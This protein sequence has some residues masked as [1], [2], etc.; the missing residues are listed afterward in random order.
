M[1][2]KIIQNIG[3]FTFNNTTV[4]SDPIALK[5]GYLRIAN[6]PHFSH[7]AIGTDV[8]A[9]ENDF[10]VSANESVIL[11]EKVS[12][13]SIFDIVPGSVTTIVAPEG[14]GQPFEV[15]DYISI[16]GVVN[17]VGINTN[18]VEVLSVSGRIM[19]VNLDTSSETGPFEFNN[20]QSR[21]SVKIS[22]SSTHGSAYAHVSE[23][24]IA[25]G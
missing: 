21:R 5:S 2:L 15:G 13:Q 8:V 25:G 17:P 23:V 10:G 22:L 12:M 19:T 9:N 18:W 20:A 4:T 11:K 16:T 1:A 14:N 24:Q 3:E 6:G 7:V